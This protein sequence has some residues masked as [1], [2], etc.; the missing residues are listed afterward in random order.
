MVLLIP[1]SVPQSV[2]F[3]LKYVV[4]AFFIS[5]G[6]LGSFVNIFSVYKG[7]IP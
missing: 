4:Q 5:R 3:I 1:C 2:G 6:F 7:Y